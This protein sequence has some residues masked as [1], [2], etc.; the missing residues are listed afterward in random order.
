MPPIRTSYSLHTPNTD[1][2]QL[3][4]VAEHNGGRLLNR[5]M[6]HHPYNTRFPHPNAHY[7][8]DI[9]DLPPSNTPG[10]HPKGNCQRDTLNLPPNL[11]DKISHVQEAAV[12]ESTKRK[13]ASRLREF[14]SFC[15]SLGIRCINALP[16][17]EEVL[18]A[19]ASS[20]VG[21]LAG[22]TVA[23][24]L[25]AIRKEHNR[26]G[27]IWAGGSCL[28]RILK[29]VEELR[30]LSSFRSKRAPVTISMLEDLR[31]GLSRY[32]HTSH[33]SFVLFLPTQKW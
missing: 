31:K 14:L 17:R 3:A 26:C 7:Q 6:C 8:H 33:P 29:G 15:E 11:R 32:L 22:K 30:L 28:R 20:Y 5:Y 2:R 19:W 16:A 21:R 1:V 13:D 23:A 18:L 10:S 25:L 27:L 4:I 24:K 12:N 9:F